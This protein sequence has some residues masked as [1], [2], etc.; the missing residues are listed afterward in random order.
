M[1]IFKDLL[2]SKKFWA[3][4]T[5]VIVTGAVSL[6]PA[7]EPM[8]ANLTEIIGVLAAYIV[9]QGIADAGKEKAKIEAK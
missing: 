6:I 9:G 4:L 8:E 3:A 1:D 2:G 5:A 7:L